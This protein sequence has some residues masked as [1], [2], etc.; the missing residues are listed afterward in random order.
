VASSG[1]GDEPVLDGNA[2]PAVI[3][4]VGSDELEVVVVD[5]ITDARRSA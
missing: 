2:G 5:P 1:A 4:L 3:E